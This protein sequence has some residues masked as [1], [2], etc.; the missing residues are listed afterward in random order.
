[1]QHREFGGAVSRPSTDC[2]LSCC[3]KLYNRVGSLISGVTGAEKDFS[4]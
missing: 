1:M 2:A 4:V 3:A